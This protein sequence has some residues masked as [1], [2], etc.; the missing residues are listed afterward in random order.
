MRTKEWIIKS[1]FLSCNASAS[2][3]CNDCRSIVSLEWL[4]ACKSSL[5]L[6]HPRIIVA[7][8]DWDLPCKQLLSIARRLPF[9][10]ILI[11]IMP[12]GPQVIWFLSEVHDYM[13]WV[14][15]QSYHNSP[16][17]CT[18]SKKN[19]FHLPS[20]FLLNNPHQRLLP[21]TRRGDLILDDPS[22]ICPCNTNRQQTLSR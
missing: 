8:P 6:G 1:E 5:F 4:I 13:R 16:K 17:R 20:Q 22:L 11:L 2:I 10:L 3:P 12:Q 19:R 18:I 14:L 15:A 21:R 9:S 7:G